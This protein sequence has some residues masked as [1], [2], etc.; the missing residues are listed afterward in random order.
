MK[1]YS[2]DKPP[3]L[4]RLRVRGISPLS[5][6]LDGTLIA[7]AMFGYDGQTPHQRCVTPTTQRKTTMHIPVNG[8]NTFC[9]TGSKAF[10]PALPTVVFIHGVLNDHSV[11]ALPTQYFA[12]HGWNVLA[13]DLPG[14]GHSAGEPPATVE[15]ASRFILSLLDAVGVAQAALVGHSFG[16]LIALQT[17]ADA[18]SRVSHLALVGTAFPMRVS[19]ALLD[20]SL[21]APQQAMEQVSR[22]SHA[23]PALTS[24]TNALMQRVLASN[25]QTNLLHTGFTA[26]DSYKN[27]EMAIDTAQ[28]ATLFIVGASDKMTPSKA[29]QGLIA[30]AKHPTVVTLAA[31]HALMAEAPDGVLSALQ[32]FLNG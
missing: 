19:P 20:A 17:A 8:H 14:H 27:G 21:N 28:V 6:H 11:W 15:A 24:D 23:M 29:A 30:R 12:S 10:N 26:C 31:G 2:P 18:P 13:V 7:S 32:S 3:R 16:S 25:L 4:S 22:Y 5:F 1:D 9:D